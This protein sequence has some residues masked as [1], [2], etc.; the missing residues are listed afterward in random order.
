MD[1]VYGLIITYSIIVLWIFSFTF[2]YRKRITCMVGMM[3]AMTMG[4]TI[5]ITLGTI[6][7]MIYPDYLFKT[8]VISMLIGGITG[9]IFGLH[10]SIMGVLDGLLSGIMGGMMGAML[11]TMITSETYN[12]VINV[13]GVLSAGIFF[14]LFLMMQS[15][16]KVKEKGWKYFFFA[17]PMPLFL[18]VLFF[19]YITNQY[20]YTA[21]QAVKDHSEHFNNSTSTQLNSNYSPIV[22][23]ANEFNY[24]LQNIDVKKGEVVT[25]I[26]KNN[27]NVDHD[28]EI[29]GTNIHLH[30]KPGKQNSTT[31]SIEKNGQYTAICT[32]PN[33][34]EKGMALTITVL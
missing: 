16:I 2:L 17:K 12:T 9:V 13:L 10:I 33:H 18:V 4:M 5:G 7:G 30:S 25:I 29:V 31:F 8:T 20:Y 34:Q 6:I 23:E 1:S 24:S 26:L 32:L 19:L 21:P 15:E 22:I 27:G 14:I 3:I 11:G 28:L